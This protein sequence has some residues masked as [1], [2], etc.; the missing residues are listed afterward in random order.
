[1]TSLWDNFAVTGRTSSSELVGRSAELALLEDALAGAGSSATTVLVSGEPG[2]G[3]TRLV[4]ELCDRAAAAGWLVATGGCSPVTGHDL[5]YGG[6]VSVLRSLAREVGDD[7]LEP[8]L[9]ALGVSDV[10]SVPARPDAGELGRTWLFETILERVA[11]VSSRTGVVL[12]VEDI[13]WADHATLGVVDHLTRNLGERT[14]LLVCTSRSDALGTDMALR[15]FAAELARGAN[16]RRVELVGLDRAALAVMAADILGAAVSDD[17]LDAVERLAGGNPFFAEELLAA[18]DRTGVPAGLRDVVMAGVEQLSPG[19]HHALGAASVFGDAVE[20]RLLAEVVDLESIELET[21]VREAVRQGLF[22][23][24]GAGYRFRHDLVREALYDSLLPAERRRLH[25]R[26]ARVL[27]V[28]PDPDG[29]LIAE[30]ARHWWNAGDWEPA[31]RTSLAAADKA[32]T[33]Y[34]FDEAQ[35][36]FER[37]LGACDRVAPADGVA[38]VDRVEVL[39]RAA[40][41]AYWGGRGER[42]VAFAHAAVDLTDADADPIGAARCWTRLGRSAWAVGDPPGSGEALAE[43]ERLLPEGEPSVELARV[44][45]EQARW[46]MLMSHYEQAEARCRQALSTAR[47]VGGRLEEGH[48]SN[49][50]GVSLCLLGRPDEG[51]ALLRWSLEVAEEVGD[52][53]SLNRAYGNLASCLVEWAQLEEAAALTLD[54]VAAGEQ[55]GGIRLNG[56]AFNS[57]EALIRLGRWDEAEAMARDYGGMPSGNCAS[58]PLMLHVTLALLHGELDRARPLLEEVGTRTATLTDVQFRGSFHLL[59]A[60]L[61]IIEGRF[62]DASGAIEQALGLVAGTEEQSLAME[63]CAVGI[64]AVVDWAVQA[65]AERRR[66]DDAKVRLRAAELADKADEIADRPRRQGLPPLP[67]TLAWLAQGRAEAA[68]T[69]P[70]A[71]KLWEAA[72]SAW[73]SLNEPFASA[74]CRWRQA[75]A[76]LAGRSERARAT[77]LVTDAWRTAVLL[78]AEP[79]RRD[80]EDLARRARIELEMADETPSAAAAAGSDLGLT[81]REVEVLGQL[82][83]GRSDAQI[84]EALFIS[85]KTAS[86]HVSNI[87][88]KL[89]VFSRIDAGE[90]GQQAG[91]SPP[92]FP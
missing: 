9:R 92:Q 21:A 64:R 46:L 37:V 8:A 4:A 23:V 14:V 22:I 89:G 40:D 1:M 60:Q 27:D 67:R 87:L 50:R 26:L 48:A 84:A 6:V 45:C 11:A 17:R 51:L 65:R 49:T 31:L 13:Q 62:A 10:P 3:K 81:R 88:R 90:I 61:A 56:S 19:A 33:V 86:V 29:R 36:Q 30:L 82:A 83:V 68:R 58:T 12:V 91:L 72:T 75:E 52:P 39:G 70:P 78:G 63:M 41:A 34:A 28:E 24:D 32:M 43:A 76:L 80:V 66:V 77:A 5:P 69:G 2:I 79:L 20:H 74:Y 55:L 85:K 7:A 54:M 25:G 15:T 53:E 73:E 57:A 35:G 47:A 71:P 16:V 38:P 44:Q 18:G 59:E 42:A